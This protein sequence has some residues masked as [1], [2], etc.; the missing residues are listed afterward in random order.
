MD[1]ELWQ[2]LRDHECIGNEVEIFLSIFLLHFDYV[3]GKSIFPGDLVRLRKVV[4][5][6]ILI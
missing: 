4:D 2:L 6:L 3:D 1:A 5:F